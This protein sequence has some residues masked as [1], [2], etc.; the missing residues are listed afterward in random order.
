M[1]GLLEYN[2]AK[3]TTLLI[4]HFEEIFLTDEKHLVYVN[5]DKS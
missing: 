1:K 2:I 5:L 3:I 4:S